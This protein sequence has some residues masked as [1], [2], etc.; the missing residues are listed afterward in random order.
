MLSAI[1]LMT[2]IVLFILPEVLNISAKNQR[3]FTTTS[4]AIGLLLVVSATL[5]YF[6]N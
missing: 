1:L 6:I 2:G 5:T 4:E 3:A